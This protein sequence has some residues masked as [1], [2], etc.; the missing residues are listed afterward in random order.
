[1][2]SHVNSRL[3]R[4]LYRGHFFRRELPNLAVQHLNAKSSV[5]V[6]GC[7]VQRRYTFLYTKLIHGLLWR[8]IEPTSWFQDGLA[9]QPAGICDQTV[10]ICPLDKQA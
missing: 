10:N 2:S 5:L 4:L 3:Q 6:R 1:M 8:Q 7:P 9:F